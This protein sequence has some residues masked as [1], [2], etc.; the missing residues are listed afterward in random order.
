MLAI[1]A[2]IVALTPARGSSAENDLYARCTSADGSTGDEVC[3]AYINGV[4]NGIF[5]DQI[6]NEQH[7]PVC[8]PDGTTTPQV[9]DIV[10]RFLRD[11]PEGRSIK[12]GSVIGE[13]LIEQFPCHP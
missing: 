5:T 10:V 1:A 4:V 8:I 11:H 12:P 2:G 7:T 6:A 13:L 9:R 3:N